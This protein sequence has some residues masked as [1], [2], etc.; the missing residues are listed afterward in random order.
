ML[1]GR[2]QAELLKMKTLRA[3]ESQPEKK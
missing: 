3:A 2:W 1:P